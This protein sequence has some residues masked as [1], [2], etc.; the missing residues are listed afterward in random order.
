MDKKTAGEQIAQASARGRGRGGWRARRTVGGKG[1]AE[2]MIIIVRNKGEKRYSH[3]SDAARGGGSRDGGGGGGTVGGQDGGDPDRRGIYIQHY[4]YVTTAPS[5][6]Q[7]VVSSTPGRR[8]VFRSYQSSASG[9][10]NGGA[11]E[12][13]ANHK[14]TMT[15]TYVLTNQLPSSC[16]LSALTAPLFTKSSCRHIP[17]RRYISPCRLACSVAILSTGQ[18]RLSFFSRPGTLTRTSVRQEPDT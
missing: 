1:T 3:R 15:A 11:V 18:R 5:P 10:S 9:D 14:P 7:S 12:R 4:A 8:V 6:Q 2:A 17:F 16:S 13:H